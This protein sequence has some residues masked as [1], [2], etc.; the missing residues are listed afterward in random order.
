MISGRFAACKQRH[1]LRD[2]LRCRRP[3]F[4]APGALREEVVRVVPGVRLHVLRQRQ[5]HRAGL[6]RVGEHPHRLRQRGEKLFG[7]VDAVEEA[8]HR[9]KAVVHAH[10]RRQ[11][12]LQL[13]QHRPL[14]A[15]GV[16]VGGE[17]Q[18]RHAVDGGGGRA[19]H[20]VGGARPDRAG[21]GQRLG[22]QR[23]AREAGRGMHHRLLVAGLVV[24]QISPALLQRLPQTAHVAVPEDAED[25]RDQPP[26]LTVEFAVLN[27]QKLYESLP[28]GQ[29]FGPHG[30]TLRSPCAQRQ[31]KVV[32]RWRRGSAPAEVPVVC[33]RA[34]DHP[35]AH[36]FLLRS[37]PAQLILPPP[38]LVPWPSPPSIG[39]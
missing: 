17:Q 9:A 25:G 28:H 12:V 16:V 6:G 8:A 13:L 4:D 36:R 23:G 24:G 26:P 39:A 19:G 10:V 22:A 7:T 32:V 2:P 35:A 37:S 11:R 27:R 34:A 20:H 30:A 38:L 29:A 5:G 15:S 21:A 14:V 18:H 1:R 3:A 31:T 33:R